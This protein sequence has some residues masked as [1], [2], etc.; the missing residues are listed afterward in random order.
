MKYRPRTLEA[1]VLRAVAHFPAVLVTGPRRSGK[2]T[3]L[4]HLFPA[5]QH[6]LM[7]DP[8]AVARVR[9]DPR[10]FL[11][12]LTPPVI[13]DEMQNAPE[14]FAYVRTRIDRHPE[15]KGQWLL[16]GSQE[17]PLMKGV[18]ESMAGRAAVFSLLPFSA[19]EAPSMTLLRGGFPEVLAAPGA[20]DIWFRSYMQTYLERDVRAVTSIRD[21]ST[22]RRFMGLLAG[23]CGQMLNKTELAA[24]LGVSVPTVTQ[25]LGIL[26][27]TGQIILT[28]PYFENFGKRIV[29]T[30]KLH[31]ADSGLAAALLG[32]RSEEA[33]ADSP[34]RG[35]LF[36]GLVASEIAKHRLNR[37]RE[38]GLYCFRDRQGLEVD[39]VVDEGARRLLLIEAKATRTPMPDDAR[40][41]VRLMAAMGP[42]LVSRAALVHADTAEHAAPMPL[43]PGV[44]AVGWRALHAWLDEEG[45]ARE[46]E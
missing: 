32:V 41:L 10:S 24:P 34:F 27:V 46:R 4:R 12:A 11:D 5:A 37:G 44:R 20:A 3:L 13:L 7:E 26:E 45:E 43:C 25:W 22:F 8:D 38:R 30:P 14:L 2:T 6:V 19:E 21:L 18:T 33:L 23:R 1:E 9:A 40:S 15:Q 36:E 16:T 35:P 39:F 28:P 31:F 17:A 42:R 29:K